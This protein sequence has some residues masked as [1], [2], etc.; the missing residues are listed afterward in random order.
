MAES[1]DVRVATGRKDCYVGCQVSTISLLRARAT[2]RSVVQGLAVLFDIRLVVIIGV[3]TFLT[4]LV[5]QLPFK[6]HF[7][8]GSASGPTRDQQF[9]HGFYP[10]GELKGDQARGRKDAARWSV[11]QEA[12]I[13]IPGVGRRGVVVSLEIVSHRAQ[14]EPDAPPTVVQLQSGS[15]PPV[16]ITL[17]REGA[18]YQFYLPPQALDDGRLRLSPTTTV[19][20]STGGDSKR[21]LGIAIAR[22]V[23]VEST[24]FDGLVLPDREMLVGWLL[25]LVWFWVLVRVIGFARRSAQHILLPLAVALPSLLLLD[26]ARVGLSGDWL[27]RVGLSMLMLATV[28]SLSLPILFRRL[29]VVVPLSLRRWLI[30]LIVLSFGLKYGGRLYPE[31]FPGDI[32]LHINRYFGAINGQLYLMAKHRGLPFPFPPGLYVL[33]APLTL[34]GLDIR[35]LFQLAA[36]LLEASAVLLVYLIVRYSGGGARLGIVAAAIYTLTA[37]GYMTIWHSFQTHISTQWFGTL[38]MLVLVAGWPRYRTKSIGAT[39]TLLVALVFLGHIGQFINTV[40]LGL[41]IVPVLWWRSRQNSATRASVYWLLVAGLVAGGMAALFYYSA[42]ADQIIN[43]IVEAAKGG[44]NAMTH[45][46]NIP[47]S[48]TLQVLWQGG[49]I[50]HFGFFPVALA[51]PGALLLGMSR[52]RRSVLLPLVWSTFAVSTS[53]ALL[54]L[55]T[56]SSLTTRWLTFAAWAITVTSAGATLQLWRRGRVGRLVVVMMG[57][58]VCWITAVVVVNAMVLNVAPIEPF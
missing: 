23:S 25:A 45:K 8:I 21:R 43:Q 50:T 37:A 3:C 24:S 58:Y 4:I 30:L 42:F 31:S 28:C 44:L 18:I 9:L 6:Y 17:R 14:W 29:D 32:Q 38:L 15:R 57:L 33:L 55:V 12:Q 53:Q 49:L 48:T 20:R 56:L 34:T 5:A 10:S 27:A 51:V 7:V 46:K 11:A 13:E 41:L 22:T 47:R 39:I 40:L 16:P 36:G 35:D 26:P 2:S 54:P 52:M 1:K 19:W